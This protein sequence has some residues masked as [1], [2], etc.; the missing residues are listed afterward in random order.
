[1]VQKKTKGGVICSVSPYLSP[2]A[3]SPP[4]CPPRWL[5]HASS[6]YNQNRT[7]PSPFSSLLTLHLSQEKGRD[8]HPALSSSHVAH[9]CTKMSALP[10][11]ST[12]GTPPPSPNP[13]PSIP[14]PTPLAKTEKKRHPLTKPT[15]QPPSTQFPN[16]SPKVQEPRNRPPRPYFHPPHQVQEPNR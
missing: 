1:M 16:L 8:K 5:S 15:Q 4:P 10:D 13:P 7:P 3:A 2:A 9:D 14:T 11:R 12:R 6:S